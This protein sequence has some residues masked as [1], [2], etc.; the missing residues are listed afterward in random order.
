MEKERTLERLTHY[1]QDGRV[2]N[3]RASWEFLGIG[4]AREHWHVLIHNAHP[5]YIS[6]PE[7]ERIEEQ[8][9]ATAKTL[10]FERTGGSPREGPALLQG[11][12]VCG[13]CGSRMH[14]H[15]TTGRRGGLT[16]TYV[17]WGRGRLFGDPLCQTVVGT[18]IDA[19]VGALLVD[20]VAPMALELAL[21]VQQEI[22]ARLDEAD[23]L[24]HR[25]VEPPTSPPCGAI[26]RRRRASLR[27]SGTAAGGWR[28]EKRTFRQPGRLSGLRS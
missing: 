18:E 25:Q 12:I 20:A 2:V 26:P 9:C 1:P 24:Q 10:G 19:A 3:T 11:R 22:T 6:W 7:Y 28:A 13:L 17:C 27:A 21:A 23:R 15:Y 8:L 4:G 5:G 16:T 14:V